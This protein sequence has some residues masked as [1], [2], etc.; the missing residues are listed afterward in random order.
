[1]SVLWESGARVGEILTLRIKHVEFD[2]YGAVAIAHGKT[3]SRRIRLVSCVPHLS[4][5]LAHHPNA[6]NRDSPLWVNIGIKHNG[7]A[8][9]YA[10]LSRMLQK[11]ARR[12]GVKKRVNPHAFRHA[13]ATDLAKVLTEAQMKE[14]F[15][16]TRS[17]EM[18]AVYVHL[19]GRDTDRAILGLYGKL[20]EAE[21][22]EDSQLRTQ[23]CTFCKFENASELEL[24]M[25][26]RRPLNLT[27]AM[28][29]ER[30]EQEF[31][32]MLT[33]QAIEEMIETKVEEILARKRSRKG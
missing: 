31:L 30:R 32:R 26:C 1:V 13:R 15:G 27:A 33:P 3:G 17:S 9:E 12:A 4:S 11:V 24:C 21:K 29:A 25:N 22:V 28:E 19:S 6:S 5:W 10:A 8:M 20:N 16:W 2:K 7:A 23:S 14:F 18:A